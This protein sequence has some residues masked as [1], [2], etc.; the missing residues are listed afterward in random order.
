MEQCSSSEQIRA[1][2]D[3]KNAKVV[4][5]SDIELRDREDESLCTCSLNENKLMLGL[6][7]G[8]LDMLLFPMPLEEEE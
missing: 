1:D 6:T 8:L 4:D 5:G 7:N 3:D 2:E